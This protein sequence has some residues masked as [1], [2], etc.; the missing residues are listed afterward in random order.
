MLPVDSFSLSHHLLQTLI[1]G[2]GRG[3]QRRGMLSTLLALASACL[4][5]N[6]PDLQRTLDIQHR[7]G[8]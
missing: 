4:L 8:R 1:G 3:K 6:C 5:G 2:R 7:S